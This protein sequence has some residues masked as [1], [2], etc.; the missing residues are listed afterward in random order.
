MKRTKLVF[1][2][3]LAALLTFGVSPASALPDSQVIAI[4]KAVAE[5]SNLELTPKAVQLVKNASKKDQEGV[6]VTVV[7]VILSK[8]PLLATDLIQAIAKAAP[9][10]SP[11]IAAAAAKVC[12]DQLEA[13]VSIAANSAPEQ[14]S[15]IAA[16]VAKVVPLGSRQIARTLMLANPMYT[17]KVVESIIA[18]VPSSEAQLK[19]D[20][21]LNVISAL[22]RVSSSS[23][24]VSRSS[25]ATAPRAGSIGKKPTVGAPTAPPNTTNAVLSAPRSVAV[26]N[27]VKQFQTLETSPSVQVAVLADA[28]VSTIQTLN[29]IGRD[30]TATKQEKDAIISTVG[31]AVS[32]LVT[33]PDISN[34][35]KTTAVRATTTVIATVMSDPD[36]T[37]A[38]KQTLVNFVSAEVQ[39]VS[40]NPRN[41]GQETTFGIATMSTQIQLA[42][43][44]SQTFTAAQLT[45]L[46][47][48]VAQQ[49]TNAINS[50]GRP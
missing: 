11:A 42:I 33:D 7:Q 38:N 31:A 22:A 2:A 41:D 16:S 5:V 45:T 20:Y 36:L 9:E 1:A 6:A 49:V 15:Q 37:I 21:T 14:A 40:T 35:D 25:A 46:T 50:Y 43:A 27:V 47:N 19:S 29:V 32:T 18:A 30:G 34:A 8:K 44:G 23:A 28:T 48:Q 13:I 17:S 24:R 39:A 3:I 4:K 10:V 26:D 12:P